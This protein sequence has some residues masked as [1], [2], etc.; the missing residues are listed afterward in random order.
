M[1]LIW[2]C[3]VMSLDVLATR[4]MR[5]NLGTNGKCRTTFIATWDCPSS[6]NRVNPHFGQV[7]NVSYCLRNN[8]QPLT[9]AWMLV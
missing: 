9:R 5:N 8:T 6:L 2:L 4:Y 3:Q 7:S 1:L